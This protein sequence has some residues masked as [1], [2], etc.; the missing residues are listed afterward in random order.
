MS[1]LFKLRVHKTHGIISVSLI[2]P[3]GNAK[4]VASITFCEYGL[5][6][7]VNYREF[8]GIKT[9]GFDQCEVH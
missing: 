1:R 6:D 9:I 8:D 2:C 3:L 4:K 7:F 5:V